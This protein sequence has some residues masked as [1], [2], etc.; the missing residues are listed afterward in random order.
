MNSGI[1]GLPTG[2]NSYGKWAI[3][4]PVWE[5]MAASPGFKASNYSTDRATNVNIKLLHLENI[6]QKI[7][8][9]DPIRL[10]IYPILTHPDLLF[11]AYE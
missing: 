9:S 6:S 3:V 4:W 7:G 2:G 11:T 1:F 8:R 5:R 10:K